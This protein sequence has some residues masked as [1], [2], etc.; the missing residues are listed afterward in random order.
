MQQALMADLEQRLRNNIEAMTPDSMLK[1]WMPAS[2][3]NVE[4]AQKMF[5][6]HMQQTLTGIATTT[7][8]A[9]TAFAERAAE[10]AK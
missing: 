2:L 10:K 8:G 4:N 6:S 1:T 9:M 3:Q 5:W 7:T